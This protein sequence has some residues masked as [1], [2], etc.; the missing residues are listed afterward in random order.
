MDDRRVFEDSL[1]YF[2]VN[3]HEYSQKGGSDE[4]EKSTY[5]ADRKKREEI[6]RSY[7]IIR[8]QEGA[9]WLA[10]P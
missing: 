2:V 8:Q 10:P 4:D 1:N 6:A 5:Q 3:V 9:S 7:V